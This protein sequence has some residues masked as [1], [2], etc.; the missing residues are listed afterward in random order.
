MSLPR[1]DCHIHVVRRGA[2]TRCT[3]TS[4]A[5]GA[6][7]DRNFRHQESLE[8]RLAKELAPTRPHPKVTGELANRL[9]M[10]VLG[11]AD[12]A[13]DLIRRRRGGA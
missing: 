10:P 12:R 4:A 13:R 8:V 5:A 11:P 6:R 1:H 3:G 9:A 7:N 2:G